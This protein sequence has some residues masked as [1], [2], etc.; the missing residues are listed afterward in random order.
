MRSYGWGPQDGISALI[1]RD[2]RELSLHYWFEM[3]VPSRKVTGAWPREI[4]AYPLH[5]A[6]RT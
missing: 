1:R 6:T 5:L 2:S 4:K 3:S